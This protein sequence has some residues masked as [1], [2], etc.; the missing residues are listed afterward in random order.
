MI[1]NR[2]KFKELDE[3]LIE[4]VNFGDKSIVPIQSKRSILLQYKNNE[5]RLLIEAHYIQAWRVILSVLA[6]WWKKTLELS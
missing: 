3:K 6:I 2:V 5:Q 1:R 4:N